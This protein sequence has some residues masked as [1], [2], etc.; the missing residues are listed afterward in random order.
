MSIYNNDI[1]KM[2]STAIFSRRRFFKK[3]RDIVEKIFSPKIQNNKLFQ[4]PFDAFEYALS[5]ETILKLVYHTDL[6]MWL[7]IL[8]PCQLSMV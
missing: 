4:T 8:G 7:Y 6:T 3:S 1:L 5:N 2:L